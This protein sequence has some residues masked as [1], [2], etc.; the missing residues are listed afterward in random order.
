MKFQCQNPECKKTFSYSAK[1][2]EYNYNGVVNEKTPF[3]HPG[4]HVVLSQIEKPVCPFCH[5]L[6]FEEY[7]EPLP[8]LVSVLSVE[9][10]DVDAKLKEG[11]EV[12]ELYAKS[13]ILIKKA[14]S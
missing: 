13:A 10:A 3:I 9:I 1:L 4:D 14:K 7:A 6:T 2:T 12:K 5:S 8:K 11:Y